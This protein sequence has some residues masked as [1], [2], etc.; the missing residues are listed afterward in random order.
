MLKTRLHKFISEDPTLRE[1]YT[2]GDIQNN[3]ARYGVNIDGKAVYNRLQWVLP[4]QQI[5]LLDWPKRAKGDL[6]QIKI[7]DEQEGFIVLFKPA[8]VVVHPG[9]GHTQE[10][11][12]D[13]LLRTI[14][15]Q[16]E[17]M[18]NAAEIDNARISAGLVHRLDKDT[19]GL[20]LVAKSLDWHKQ[21]QDLFR[22]RVVKKH[23]LAI[24]QGQL[25][26]AVEIKGWQCRDKRNPRYQK[27]FTNEKEAQWYDPQTRFSHSLFTPVRYDAVANQTLVDIEIFTGR[28]HQI[29]VQAKAVN[30]PILN[31]SIYGDHVTQTASFG[32]LKPYLPPTNLQLL[33]NSLEFEKY[34]YTLIQDFNE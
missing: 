8:G 30:M 7:V 28:M 21:L 27:F 32:V 5:R 33:S 6:T 23:Y 19:A 31:D 25:N 3:I 13:W 12:L 34:K 17:L 26:E 29:R 20:L 2:L 14:P 1:E 18:H 16:R 22:N 4:G 15:G 24:L 10:T 9:A 11:L